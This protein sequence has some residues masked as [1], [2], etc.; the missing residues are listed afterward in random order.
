MGVNFIK[1]TEKKFEKETLKDKFEKIKNGD[2]IEFE[3][4]GNLTKK[5]LEEIFEL[6]QIKH[7]FLNDC[8]IIEL[9]PTFEKFTHLELLNIGRTTLQSFSAN[10]LL[11][12][13]SL[14]HLCIPPQA[15][16]NIPEAI[17]KLNQLELLAIAPNGKLIVEDN[18]VFFPSKVSNFFELNIN[19]L[20]KFSQIKR[21]ELS[22]LQA[23]IIEKIDFSKF[24]SVVLR[25][26]SKR[27]S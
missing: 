10:T 19:E 23:D 2:T 11:K 24:K 4:V 18:N 3:W 22:G 16:I 27:I 8:G 13:K 20:Y 6:K 17:S 25:Y 21:L 26:K 14:K 7:L 1:E 15:L 5:E 12:L 9:P